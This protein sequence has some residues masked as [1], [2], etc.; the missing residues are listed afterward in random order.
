MSSALVIDRGGETV[1]EGEMESSFFT[2]RFSGVSTSGVESTSR[3]ELE[4]PM[5]LSVRRK[6]D[7]ELCLC[8]DGGLGGGG[9]SEQVSLFESLM[10]RARFKSAI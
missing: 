9:D 7:N 8:F 3:S 5:W 4:E 6:G 1:S 2:L 10:M